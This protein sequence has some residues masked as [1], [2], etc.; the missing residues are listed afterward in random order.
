VL[1]NPALVHWSV[2]GWN[3]AQDSNARDTGLGTYVL[4]LPT[5]S[6]PAGSKATFTFYWTQEN[7]W[8]GTDFSVI[9]E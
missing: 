9:V 5:A 4:D 7:R 6:L 1:F 3:S 2:D 8:E